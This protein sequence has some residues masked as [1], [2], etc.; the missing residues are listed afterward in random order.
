MTTYHCPHCHWHGAPAERA[1]FDDGAVVSSE[2]WLVCENCGTRLSRSDRLADDQHPCERCRRAVALVPGG[3]CYACE[4]A[5]AFDGL[6]CESRAV[7]TDFDL[8]VRDITRCQ[9]GVR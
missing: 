4:I 2:S 7:V 9:A 1:W 5:D 8:T 3:Y 6:V